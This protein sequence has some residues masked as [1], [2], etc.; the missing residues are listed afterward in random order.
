MGHYDNQIA[1]MVIIL[2][3]FQRGIETINP[4]SKFIISKLQKHLFELITSHKEYSF[5]I[6]VISFCCFQTKKS[7]HCSVKNTM[8]S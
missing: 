3:W 7:S 6:K 1:S 2:R 8:L 5:L 4:H